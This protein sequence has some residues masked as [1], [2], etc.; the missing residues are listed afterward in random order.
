MK[1]ILVALAILAYC[2][3]CFSQST[4]LSAEK[5]LDVSYGSFPSS[6][7]DL[8]LPVNR[9]KDTPFVIIIHG[10]GWVAGDKKSDRGAQQILLEQGIASANINYRFVD[11]LNIHYPQMIADIDSA[12]SYC[13]ARSGEWNTRAKDFVFMGASAGGHLSLLYAYTGRHKAKA[14][15]AECAPVDLTD[16]TGIL[17]NKTPKELQS[18]VFKMAGATYTPGKPVDPKFKAS[19][20]IY[21]VKNIPTLMVHGTEDPI[22]PYAQALM[23]RDKLQSKNIPNKLITIPGAGHDMNMKDLANRTMIYKEIVDWIWGYNK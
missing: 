4:Y 17:H 8:Y 15:I 20:P 18:I 12:V 11:S 6:K 5:Q 16:T 19:S 13:A 14:I 22:V 7:M 9:T 23:L 2:L 1:K 21:H 3:P 10:G